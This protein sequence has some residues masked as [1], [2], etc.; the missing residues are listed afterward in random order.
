[1]EIKNQSPVTLAIK[2]AK[3]F[4]ICHFRFTMGSW[5]W[6]QIWIRFKNALLPRAGAAGVRRAK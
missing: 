1:V 5:T 3:E 4:T 2:L 6:P